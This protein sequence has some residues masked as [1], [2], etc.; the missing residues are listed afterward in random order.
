MW[1]DYY[2]INN[3]CICK[4]NTLE[5]DRIYCLANHSIILKIT[6]NR[7]K[8]ESFYPHIPAKYFDTFPSG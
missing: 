5:S 1:L 2:N 6:K 4:F 3:K 7:G 8:Y